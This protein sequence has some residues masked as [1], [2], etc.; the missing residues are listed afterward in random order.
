VAT[1]VIAELTFLEAARRK[2]LWMAFVVSVIFLIVYAL[3]F[4]EIQKDLMRQNTT[5]ILRS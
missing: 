3:G 5:I 4:N 1:F 2:I